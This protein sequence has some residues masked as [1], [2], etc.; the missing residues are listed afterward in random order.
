MSLIDRDNI[1]DNRANP[2]IN[3]DDEVLNRM[4]HNTSGNTNRTTGLGVKTRMAFKNGVILTYDANN[5]VSSVFGYIPELS[6]VPVL[7]IA[8]SGYDVYVDILGLT[9]PTI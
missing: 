6:N 3:A 7:I 4:S 2:S 8:K 5:K 9:A 1:S